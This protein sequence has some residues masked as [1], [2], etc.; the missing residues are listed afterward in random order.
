MT[1]AFTDIEG[2][3]QRWERDRAAMQEAVRRH[4][5]LV[6]EA[7]EAHGGHVFKTM[8]DGF[9]AAFARPQDAV[10]AML[11]AQQTLA[12]QD[13][14]AVDGIRV[15]AAIHVGTADERDGD[16]FGPAVNRVARLLAIAHGG[17]ILVS[18]IAADLVA[19][20]LPERAMLHDLGSHRLKDLAQPEAV[21]QLQAPDL[22]ANF[23]PLR[24]LDALPNNLPRMPTSFVG[25]ETEIAEIAALVEAHQVVTLVGS[26]G[27][28]KTR[29][30]LQVA[31]NLLDGSGDGVWFVE[32]APL[33]GGEYIAPTVAQVLGLVALPA[34]DPVAHLVRALK[35][36]R[37]LLVF[38]NCEHVVEDAGRIVAALVR[39]CPQLKLL[40]SSRQALGIAGE[41]TY[42]MPSLPV[43]A[44]S[45]AGALAA[46]EAAEF[47]AVALFSERARA[48]DHRFVLGDD[49]ADVVA[50]ICRR[51][52]GIPLAIELAA[53]RVKLLSPVQ[54]RER[55]DERLRVLTGGSRDALPRQQTLRALI[56][57]SYDLLDERERK[58]FCRLGIFV[59]GFALEGAVAVA[60]DIDEFEVF[61]LLA[62]LVDKSLVLAEPAGEAVRYRLLESTRVYAREKLGATGE[63]DVCAGHHLGYLRDRFVAAWQRHMQTGRHTEFEALLSSE[64][65]DI[66][67]A[68]DGA[69]VRREIEAGAE[70]LAT[71]GSFWN[72]IGLQR[73]GLARSEAFLAVLDRADTRLLADLAF[74]VSRVATTLLLMDR[75]YETAAL[76]LG[77]A[78]AAGDRDTLALTMTGY[79]FAASRKRR[80]DEVPPLLAELE[81]LGTLSAGLELFLLEARVLFELH[82]GRLETHLTLLEALRLKQRALGNVEAELIT[83]INLA[84]AEHEFGRTLPA[85]ELLRE[86]LPR[87]GTSRQCNVLANLAGYLI[88]VDDF[89][90][91]D[92]AAREALRMLLRREADSPLAAAAVEHLALVRAI[93]GD[94]DLAATLMG[95]AEN[96][97]R[98]TG[99]VRDFT[100]EVTHE[101]LDA[102]L[103]SR[104]E[105]N[106]LT[107]LS[108]RGAALDPDAAI[109]LAL[110]TSA[111]AASG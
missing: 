4:D 50:D 20:S 83:T 69:L 55:L 87:C 32:L 27:L 102:L 8:G 56:D 78:R 54:L 40:A 13:F 22:R 52:D 94:S 41:M 65:E 63:L 44:R 73:E 39:G 80:I 38:D 14:S 1:F 26:G 84:E 77:A 36:M 29:T 91:A 85:I 5:A 2:S 11:D 75:A 31:A 71:C 105:S 49:N 10:A 92:A 100:E 70:L 47:A 82:S 58:L 72:R 61:D 76:A 89:E 25:R 99:T 107:R 110:A 48:A 33:A 66:R 74:A 60:P 104:L 79:V 7:I 35:S 23:P 30:A 46:A 12:A 21:Y 64:L 16:Y 42:R 57:W 6:R 101:R 95:Y 3:T 68:L 67:A 45:E 97:Y 88:G 51:L 43:P 34:G 37:A 98:Q 109:A 93:A 90:A 81:Q 108:A 15:R 103:Q 53:A 111:T 17:Q 62:S 28:G 18:G 106:T 24:S 19:G 86:I 96:A 59:N 9:C